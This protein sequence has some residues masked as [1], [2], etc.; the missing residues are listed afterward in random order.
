MRFDED[1]EPG[2]WRWRNL[3]DFGL[4]FQIWPLSW[5]VFEFSSGG[6]QYGAQWIAQIGPLVF[7]LDVNDGS[8]Q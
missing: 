1:L 4:G 2:V 6:D 3:R 8:G 7:T 5:W